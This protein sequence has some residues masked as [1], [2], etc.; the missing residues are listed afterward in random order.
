[1]ATASPGDTLL[2]RYWGNGHTRWDIGSPNHRDP[3][4]VRIFWA[5]KPETEIVYAKDLNE[6]YW[7]PGAQG[8]FS[9]DT[10][11]EITNDGKNMNEKANYFSFTIPEKIQNGRQ[12]MVWAWAWKPSLVNG[13]KGDPN[14]YDASW[15]NAWGT[16]FDI[17]IEGSTFTGTSLARAQPPYWRAIANPFP[18]DEA[19]TDILYNKPGFDKEAASKKTA[20]EVCSVSCY[21]GGM[22]Q[23]SMKCTG[24]DCPPCRY[25]SNGEATCY[26]YTSA[27]ACP[28]SGAFDCKT[29]AFATKRDVLTNHKHR[30]HNHKN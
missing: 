24:N 15:D 14:V 29:G 30:R 4:L 25:K 20:N 7:I 1:M 27:G 2:M 28:F 9:A 3:G 6:A 5:G 10:V 21:K 13:E 8:N 19:N 23:D 17:Q 16:C 22:V 18:A 11:T 26:D 12:S